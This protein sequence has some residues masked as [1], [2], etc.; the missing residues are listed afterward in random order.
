MKVKEVCRR[1]KCTNW[2]NYNSTKIICASCGYE[3]M[4]A[5]K[6]FIPCKEEEL[7]MNGTLEYFIGDLKE[8]GIEN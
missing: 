4:S 6:W 1:C 8:Y 5:H 2:I 3:R 7:K